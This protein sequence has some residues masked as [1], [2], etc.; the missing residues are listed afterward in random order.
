MT[1]VTSSWALR[2][3]GLTRAL[4][5]IVLCSLW[6]SLLDLA[7][8]AVKAVLPAPR[9]SGLLALFAG[10]TV[11]VTAVA[12]VVFLV[13]CA[14]TVLAKRWSA[15]RRALVSA[16]LL[17][18]ACTWPAFDLG[19]SLASGA[20]IARSPFAALVHYG[21]AGIVVGL[22]LV[23]LLHAFLARPRWLWAGLWFSAS[24]VCA[25][26]NAYV[27]VGLYMK[28]HLALY[29]GSL[30]TG[31][32]AS[33][34]V[35]F[36]ACEHESRRVL[37]LA[38]AFQALGLIGAP[39]VSSGERSYVLRVSPTLADLVSRVAPPAD[40]RQVY[41]ML[42]E[43]R[44]TPR[45]AK[46]ASTSRR[47]R[48]PTN[49]LFL[50][51]DTLRADALP[52]VRTPDAQYVAAEDTPFLN[53]WLESTYRFHHAYSQGPQTKRSLPYTFRSV[54]A[55]DDPARSGIGL[56]ERMRRLGKRPV[57]IVPEYFRTRE[58]GDDA[59]ALL[60]GFERVHVYQPGEQ[61]KL[62]S[63]T[64]HLLN[65]VGREPFFAWVHFFCMHSPYFDGKLQLSGKQSRAEQY[66]HALR[67]L[68]GQLRE[69]MTALEEKHLQDSTLVVLMS[70]HGEHL[71]ELGRRGH[72][73]GL[74]EQEL[75]VPL[76]FRVPGASGGQI[77][78][79]AGNVDVIPT[80]VDLLGG[81]AR[82]ADRGQSLVAA[83]QSGAKNSDRALYQGT[84]FEMSLVT[85]RYRFGF[86]SR[87]GVFSLYDRLTDP[88]DRNDLFGTD[89]ARDLEFL[90]ELARRNPAPFAEELKDPGTIELLATR[91]DSLAARSPS[92]A[93]E[94]LLALARASKSQKA[95][96]AG[97][98]VFERSTSLEVR[99]T[100]VR[101][102]F[103]ADRKQWAET[104]VAWLRS[105]EGTPDEIAVVRGLS[106]I[107][108]PMF[109]QRYVAGRLAAIAAHSP[110]AGDLSP[111]AQAWLT[112]TAAWDKPADV[113][114]EP[115]RA[116]VPTPLPAPEPA[117][118]GR[119]TL[120]L[121]NFATLT[122]VSLERASTLEPVLVPYLHHESVL[123]AEAACRA[124]G[125]VGGAMA[126]P[127]LRVVVRSGRDG[128]LRREALRALALRQGGA[129]TSLLVDVGS[130][131]QLTSDVVRLLHGSKD[132]TAQR[133]L[134][135]TSKQ[136]PSSWTRRE[137]SAALKEK[138]P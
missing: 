62:V 32:L 79:L 137:A 102:L 122:K 6:L 59:R 129:E 105:V 95:L 10:H 75:R 103:G 72:G 120:L 138:A 70:D 78:A 25:L 107:A 29:A 91:L 108:Q 80:I 94:T 56:A 26:A 88:F 74:H 46:P 47:E 96:A 64:K 37:L 8:A 133:F 112:L 53:T 44:E 35:V 43:L 117:R 4:G 92:E 3:R 114:A 36:L 85:Q 81:S 127:E 130:D 125:T 69:L 110:S 121:D 87:Q 34:Q 33:V 27:F 71:G 136:N 101:A 73:D 100:V 106:D 123:V 42:Q 57:A 128:R 115:L 135:T 77:E 58:A 63:E 93:L 60:D 48:P 21:T 83:M 30:A 50:V 11:A 19:R 68:D 134:R 2:R 13:R 76:A 41:G 67:W 31:L 23:L 51:V 61:A 24:L 86:A 111:L 84:K 90:S 126:T 116:L 124:L 20:S 99:L 52:P 12:L 7:L 1:N 49:V 28:A 131:P 82:P 16:G 104:L 45:V 17:T 89:P 9:L 109:A 66:R 98:R 18:L 97:K 5:P 54:E 40:G 65:D 113:F 132:E 22:V 14:V 118:D 119:V 55:S 38:A 15:E 39:L